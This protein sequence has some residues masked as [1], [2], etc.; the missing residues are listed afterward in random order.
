MNNLLDNLKCSYLPTNT[1]Y[2]PIVIVADKRV[3]K[4]K[5]TD[6]NKNNETVDTVLS[7]LPF[8]DCRLLL[9]TGKPDDTGEMTYDGDYLKHG[10]ATG[11]IEYSTKL[12]AWV[13]VDEDKTI[14]R[15]FE[16]G[17]EV[18][19]KTGNKYGGIQQ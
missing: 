12:C 7:Q 19:H 8:D 18:M 10:D 2:D 17:I 16:I 3:I 9:P 14:T 13:V 4:V 6:I 11:I 1:I 15:L 5:K